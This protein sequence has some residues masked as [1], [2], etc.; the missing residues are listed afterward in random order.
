MTAATTAA[1]ARSARPT[2]EGATGG[3]LTR[4]LARLTEAK[5]ARGKA[6]AETS[7]AIGPKAIQTEKMISIFK[8]NLREIVEIAMKKVSV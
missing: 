6:P 4:G 3:L 8:K 1:A 2:T 5:A 7:A